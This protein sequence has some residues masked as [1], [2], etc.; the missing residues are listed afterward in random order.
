M[1]MPS[2]IDAQLFAPCGIDCMVC[3][4]HC[5]TKKPC[6]GCLVGDSGKPAHCR[7]CRIKTCA[8]EKGVTYCFACADFPCKFIKNLEKSYNQ[9]YDESLVANSILAQTQGIG[10]VLELHQQKYRCS[11]CGGVVS[12][13]DTVCTDC[14]ERK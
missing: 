7:V 3:Y 12:M 5:L 2:R 10:Q 9:R 11:H 13:H 6:P 14:G 8:T 1:K 4:K